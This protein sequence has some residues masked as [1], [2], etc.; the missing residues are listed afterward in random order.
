MGIWRPFCTK[1]AISRSYKIFGLRS[2]TAVVFFSLTIITG[3]RVS[4]SSI[5]DC[6]LTNIFWLSSDCLIFSKCASNFSLGL[7]QEIIRSCLTAVVVV[8]A[9]K[10]PCFLSSAATLAIMKPTPCK[11]FWIEFHT[12]ADVLLNSIVNHLPGF[13]TL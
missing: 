6:V 12:D 7:K 1:K 11:A 3:R 5:N 4:S 10:E 2:T 13:N 8:T 9:L